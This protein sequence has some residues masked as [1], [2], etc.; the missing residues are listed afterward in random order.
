MRPATNTAA[1]WCVGVLMS[2]AIAA[3]GAASVSA[4]VAL[5]YSVPTDGASVGG[6][7][8]EVTVAFTEPVRL[9]GSGFE[10]LDPQN[11]LLRPFAV[12]DD[13]MVFRLQ[14]DPPLGG[15]VV[16]IRYS[17]LAGGGYT[18]NGAFSFTVNAAAP[19]TTVPATNVPVTNP[20]VATSAGAES[21]PLTSP[22]PVT[23]APAVTE[24]PL[25][26]AGAAPASTGAPAPAASPADGGSNRT[27]TLLVCLVI[28]VLS[29]G[30]L[31]VRPR[32]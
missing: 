13:D 21:P 3:S 30:F 24:A 10:A 32:P 6:P 8:A 5:D 16:G 11:N 25:V 4:Q 9:I 23:A 19:T 7:I 29:G 17:V 26:V 14:F 27:T 2:V 31:L 20:A 15:G 12:T 28:V 18:L 1:R 22:A